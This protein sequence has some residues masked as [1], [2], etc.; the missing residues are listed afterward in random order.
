MTTNL[1]N[2]HGNKWMAVFQGMEGLTFKIISAVIPS[3]SAGVSE[4]GGSENVSLV[5]P[6]DHVVLDDLSFDFLIDE[7][8]RNYEELYEWLLAC[9]TENEPTLRDLSIHLLDTNGNLRGLRIDFT[10]AWPVVLTG[11]LFDIENL[12]SDLQSSV[13]IKYE[14]MKFARSD[15]E[16]A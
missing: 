4:L 14:R 3:A 10:N 12:T 7:D 9:T 5:V 1:N 8:F 11:F 6:G 2:A 13:Q 15:V 16:L